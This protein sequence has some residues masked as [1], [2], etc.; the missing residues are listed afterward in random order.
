M[1]TLKHLGRIALTQRLDCILQ[2]LSLLLLLFM[3]VHY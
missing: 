2:P 3:M 1:Q